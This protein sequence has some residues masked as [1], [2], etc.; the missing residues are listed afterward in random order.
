VYTTRCIR[1]AHDRRTHVAEPEDEMDVSAQRECREMQDQEWH[2]FIQDD[3]SMFP[4]DHSSIQVIFASG[5]LIKGT[6]HDGMLPTSTKFLKLRSRAGDT[7]DRGSLAPGELDRALA[8]SVVRDTPAL[9]G[10]RAARAV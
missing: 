7:S 3:R 10:L 4:P 2:E 1:K 6:W 8:R 9:Y 5:R